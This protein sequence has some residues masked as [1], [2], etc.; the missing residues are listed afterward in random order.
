MAS[1]H[2][3][4][5]VVVVGADS[6]IGAALMGELRLRGFTA[7]G[8]SRRRSC[9]HFFLDLEKPI[10]LSVLPEARTVFLCAGMNGFAACRELPATAALVN[11]S[12][13]LAIGT[14]YLE[15]GGHVVFLSSAA[16]FGARSDTPNEQ[17]APT[18]NTTY[19]AFK[20][21][22]EIA[23][24]DAATVSGGKCSIVRLTK[25][26]SFAGSLLKKWRTQGAVDQTIDAFMDVSIAPISLN[27]L[28][29]GLLEVADSRL[30][31]CFHFAGAQPLTYADLACA[32]G[33]RQLVPMALINRTN[34][35]ATMQAALPPQ[36]SALGMPV[37][38]RT[39]GIRPQSFANFLDSVE[40]LADDSMSCG[41]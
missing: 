32:L 6:L 22:T 26:L 3:S 39:L 21:A 17:D 11:V 37:T 15:Q 1:T 7:V 10:D 29:N 35:S 23:L 12:A 33:E 38:L 20:Y 19:G 8:T 14:H 4:E 28:V 36:C 2:P 18:P 25:V 5:G 40:L 13:T 9:A 30:T 27:Y 16:V 31:G 41:T 24:L 34:E